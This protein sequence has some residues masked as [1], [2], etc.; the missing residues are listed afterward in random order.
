MP[1]T[2]HPPRSLPGRELIVPLLAVFVVAVSP[3]FVWSRLPDPMAIHWGI[4]GR[5]DGSGP[6]VLDVILLA[7]VTA[8]AT[9]LP[10]AAAAR[11]DRRVARSMLGLSY[12]M[13]ALFVLLRW[14]TLERNLDATVWSDAGSISLLDLGILLFAAPFIAAGWWLGGRHPELPRPV[15]VVLP[16]TLPADG[17]LLWT[18]RQAWPLGRVLGPALVAAG[19]ASIG[20][21]IAAETMVIGGTLVL[22]G[23]LL[24][25]FTTI[26]V[27]TG[28]GGLRVRFGPIGWPAIHV[29]LAG[30]DSIEVEDIEPLAFGGWGYRV[31]PGVRAVVIR[32]GIGLRVRR[33]ERA[34]LVVTID[35]A[36]TAAGVLAAHLAQH[37]AEEPPPEGG[38]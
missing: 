26:A 35:D 30:I 6:L 3:L 5:P 21:R 23:L 37:R 29:P 12:G 32:R 1:T 4:D 14:L 17:R 15:R 19:A 31:M 28:P 16:L 34:D 2:L 20:M 22:V 36:A 25:W 9:L 33:T 10:L 13:A 27:A 7:V 18:G 38:E 11:A 24:W 8:L